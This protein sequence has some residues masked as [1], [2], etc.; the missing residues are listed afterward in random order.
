MGIICLVFS[1][2]LDIVFHEILVE[3]LLRLGAVEQTVI[4]IG[5]WLSGQA[6]A[7][8]IF[9]LL[10]LPH[11]YGKPFILLILCLICKMISL[12]FYLGH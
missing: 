7:W 9:P 8:A 6:R 4:C 2:A 5:N 12:R 1:K 10:L 11:S 3:K